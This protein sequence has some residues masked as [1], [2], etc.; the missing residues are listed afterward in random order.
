MEIPFNSNDKKEKTFS[1]VFTQIRDNESSQGFSQLQN[2]L[3]KLQHSLTLLK[4][5]GTKTKINSNRKKKYT[6]SPKRF[7]TVP[8]KTIKSSIKTNKKKDFSNQIKNREINQCPINETTKTS[9]NINNNL[10]ENLFMTNL[11]YKNKI[12]NFNINN[13]L[14]NTDYA[15]SSSKKYNKNEL[16]INTFDF[17]SFS[18][19]NN[20]FIKTKFTSK[21]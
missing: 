6:S 5:Y 18:L 15:F 8:N 19:D 10:K 1:K 17:N 11:N 3:S 7:Q 4:L 20:S 16:K 2:N 9:F 21:N 13:R 12:K 14:N